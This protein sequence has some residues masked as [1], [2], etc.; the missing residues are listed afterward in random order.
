[1][2]EYLEDYCTMVSCNSVMKVLS[3]ATA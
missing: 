3:Q 2:P 1:M